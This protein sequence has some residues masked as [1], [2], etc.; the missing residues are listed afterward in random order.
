MGSILSAAPFD[1][2]YLLFYL[3][4]LQ[5]VEFRLM[6][7]ELGVEFVLACLFLEQVSASAITKYYA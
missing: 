5:V 1:F 7:L 3:K 4:G 2:V 6:R